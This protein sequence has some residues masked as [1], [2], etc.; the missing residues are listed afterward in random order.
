MRNLAADL[1][2]W[3]SKSGDW[4]NLFAQP[5]ALDLV[6]ADDIQR[7]FTQYFTKDSRTVATLVP[8]EPK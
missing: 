3:Q 5:D 2:E 1:C 4:R 6:T 8:G 7:V